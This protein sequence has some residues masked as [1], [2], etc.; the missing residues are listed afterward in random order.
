M[1]IYQVYRT[2]GFGRKLHLTAPQGLGVTAPRLC[3]H[4]WLKRQPKWEVGNLRP[5]DSLNQGYRNRWVCEQHAMR[6]HRSGAMLFWTRWHLREPSAARQV[7]QQGWCPSS[8]AQGE[9][10]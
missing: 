2:Q 10:C 3:L 7:E 9:W 1:R 6:T 5:E 8:Q 4:C